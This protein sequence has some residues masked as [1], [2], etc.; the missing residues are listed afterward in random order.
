MIDAKKEAIEI[1]AAIIAAVAI[2]GFF[3]D[4]NGGSLDFSDRELRIVVTDLMDGDPQPYDVP[5]IRRNSLVIMTHQ[6]ASGID[7]GDVIGFRIGTEGNPIIYRV[8]S[9]DSVN[10]TLT[11]KGD[12]LSFTDTIPMGSVIG[13]VVG[14]SRPAGELALF[15]K[16]EYP[17][18]VSEV[19]AILVLYHIINV[20]FERE[21]RRLR[22]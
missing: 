7:T 19:M 20:S 11:V 9:S 8:V 2:L 14:A 16:S 21:D 12:A 13:K 10:G 15:V 18:L 22:K 3:V 5:G 4:L 6:G 1:V 17:L